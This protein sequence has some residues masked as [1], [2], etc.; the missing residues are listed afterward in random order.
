MAF[1]GTV[2]LSG[3]DD[4]ITPSQACVVALDGP[5]INPTD[6]TEEVQTHP[7]L[8]FV[9][10]IVSQ[11]HARE[12]KP[13]PAM[14][15]G[16]DGRP[17][18]I[19]LQDCLACSGCITTAETVLLQQQSVG[20]FRS[21]LAEP[22]TIAIASVSPQTRASLAVYYGLGAAEAGARLVGF[23]K[24]LGVKAV[25]DL[26]CARDVSLMEAAAEFCYRFRSHRS[27][28]AKGGDG[29]EMDVD[30]GMQSAGEHNHPVQLPMLASSCPG[31]ICYAEKTHG[32]YVLPYI[33][34]AKSPQA[35][36]GTL[37]KRQVAAR[38]GMD[39]AKV[40]HCALQPCYDKKLEASREDFETAGN[41]KETDC[42]L[43]TLEVVELLNEKGLHLK[44]C[45][46]DNM[47]SIITL[48]AG[49]PACQVEGSSGLHGWPGGSGGYVD[50]VFRVAAQELFGVQVPAGP[51]PYKTLRNSDFKEVT[52]TVDDRVVLRFATAYGFRNIQTLMR[53]IKRDQCEYHYVEIMAC[54]SGC[55]NGGG[56]MRPKEG[57]TVQ[58]LIQSLDESYHHQ[59]IVPRW[60]ADNPL[61]RFM[62]DA[63]N[64]GPCFGPQAQALFHTQYHKREKTASTAIADW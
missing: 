59:D 57:Q 12:D 40:F 43:S 2:K 6:V 7:K 14:K 37:L 49:H 53:K 32:E 45:P 31:W 54:P 46:V 42:V 3:L 1:S 23:F 60:P 4:H 8:L 44:D 11:I 50:F 30:G 24:S 13:A 34:T 35:V 33:S 21:R 20:E 26:S 51:L 18:T 29:S 58:E 61:V 48:M 9:G 28:S 25:L 47:D 39:P 5:K 27:S 63:S 17:V 10:T 15:Q 52:L 19:N 62:Y 56:Q 64:V 36:L 38:H 55:L 16:A 41:V 22:G